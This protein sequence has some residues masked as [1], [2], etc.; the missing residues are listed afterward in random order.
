[1]NTYTVS[2]FGHREIENSLETEKRLEV[3]IADI[4]QKNEY[5]EFLVG[6]EGDFDILVSSVIKRTI[7]KNGNDKAAMVLVLP[8]LKSEYV[9]NEKSFLEYYNEVEIC[10]ES[11]KA[12]YKSAI[13]IR[14]KCMV[15]RSDLVVYYIRHKNSGAYSTICYAQKQNCR[16]INVAE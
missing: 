11:S 13:Q 12:Y 9:K 14:N 16:I 3:I 10:E 5:V 15:N 2:F 1:M 8:Y 4:L 7:D 6:R